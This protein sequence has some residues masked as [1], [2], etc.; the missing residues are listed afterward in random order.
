MTSVDSHALKSCTPLQRPEA[1]HPFQTKEALRS[2]AELSNP[3]RYALVPWKSLGA[4]SHTMPQ[5]AG[6]DVAE[7]ASPGMSPSGAASCCLRPRATARQASRLLSAASSLRPELS[8]THLAGPLVES[9]TTEQNSSCQTAGPCVLP[10]TQPPRSGR[11]HEARRASGEG[12]SPATVRQDL[13]LHR[14]SR[15]QGD[16]GWPRLRKRLTTSLL[17]GLRPPAALHGERR[18]RPWGPPA[19]P[20]GSSGAPSPSP[21]PATA[22]SERLRPAAQERPS[23]RRRAESERRPRL[24]GLE[25]P[26]LERGTWPAAMR[27]APPLLPR[28][29]S[30]RR[31]AEPRVRRAGVEPLRLVV[32][33][34]QRVWALAD[35]QHLT[36]L[37]DGEL[38]R[39]LERRLRELSFPRAP[40]VEV[41]F[42]GSRGMQAALNRSEPR[43]C[44]GFQF[45][46]HGP[47]GQGSWKAT[48]AR[49]AA[50]VT[51]MRK[52]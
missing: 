26:Q 7:T 18:P 50:A 3:T 34:E 38:P 27:V 1:W 46:G 45:A 44:A 11:R 33:L 36:A 51:L 35:V 52:E 10:S 37:Q 15:G 8:A 32:D 41:G 20:P 48:S 30:G 12:R 4:R 25:V 19:T 28:A 49:F 42:P 5:T 22:A 21:E 9:S 31:H 6:P 14:A 29:P 17:P 43:K 39:V 47:H 23:A 2:A 24:Q 13:G 16:R 40:R